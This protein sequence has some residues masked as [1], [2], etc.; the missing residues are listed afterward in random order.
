MI[1]PSVLLVFIPTFFIVSV[2]PGMCMTLALTLGMT[3]GVRKTIYMMAGELVGVAMVCVAAVCGVA[4]IMLKFPTLFLLLKVCGG[5]YLVFLGFQMMR[6]KGKTDAGDIERHM[7]SI[8]PKSLAV[9]GFITAIANPKGWAFMISLLPPFIVSTKPLVPQLAVL[10]TIILG[11]EFFCLLLYSNGGRT[12]SRF[13][14]KKGN[15]MTL[16]RVSGVMMVS[17]GI[18]LGIG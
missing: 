18:W 14:K 9:Q 8:D 1:D 6:S 10:V 13:I 17:V 3:I 2:T 12:L 15:V 11:T 5:F 16:N 4:A 7:D